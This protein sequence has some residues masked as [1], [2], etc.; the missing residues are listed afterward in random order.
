MRG[1][2][3]LL[4]ALVSAPAAAQTPNLKVNFVVTPAAASQLTSAGVSGIA[5]VSTEM[6]NLNTAYSNSGISATASTVGYSTSDSNLGISSST[7]LPDAVS[8]AANSLIVKAARDNDGAD[9]TVVIISA[10]ASRA[11]QINSS[12]WYSVVVVSAQQLMNDL[13]PGKRIPC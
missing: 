8:I 2:A 5:R 1:L 7:P 10:N 13:A 6:S 3:F 9:V 12:A 4:L 11:A